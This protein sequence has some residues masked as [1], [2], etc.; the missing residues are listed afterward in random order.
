MTLTLRAPAS[1]AFVALAL[2]ACGS[3]SAD[4]STEQ[5]DDGRLLI[6]MTVAPLTSIVANVAGD[7]AD[8]GERSFAGRSRRRCRVVQDD[9]HRALVAAAHRCNAV[10]A[11]LRRAGASRE[12]PIRRS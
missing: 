3:S 1:A 11:T 10:A 8:R 2:T 5:A 4:G 12:S 6:V 7:V 9:A